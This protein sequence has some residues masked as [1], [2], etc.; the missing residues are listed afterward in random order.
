MSNVLVGNKA[1]V[2]WPQ[3][4][5]TDFKKWIDDNL[6]FRSCASFFPKA[7]KNFDRTL[8]SIYDNAI[9]RPETYNLITDKMKA[10]KTAQAENAA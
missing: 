6:G 2:K 3:D 8:K 9:S 7:K 5:H 4:V 10:M 1:R